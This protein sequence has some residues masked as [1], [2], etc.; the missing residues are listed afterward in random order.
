MNSKSSIDQSPK[1]A[2]GLRRADQAGVAAILAVGLVAMGIWW[3]WQAGIG[4]QLVEFDRA[5][6]ANFKF[7]IDPNRA[8]WPELVQ[9]PGIG[10]TLA[11]RIVKS[12]ESDGPFLNHDDLERVRG[13]GPKKLDSA[14]PYL[15]PMGGLSLRASGAGPSNCLRW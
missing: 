5:E 4:D 3:G 12:R 15:R 2:R 14:R 9:L 11:R 10:E 8:P 6:T 1:V 7:Q 13:I